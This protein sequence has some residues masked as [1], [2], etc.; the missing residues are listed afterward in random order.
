MTLE[1]KG[2]ALLLRNAL[3]LR[4]ELDTVHKVVTALGVA[5]V[6]DTDANALLDLA[7]ADG[8]VDNDTDSAGV[9]RVHNTSA[10]LV[11]L[12]VHTLL[13]ARVSD[14]V[15]NVACVEATQE[16][17]DLHLSMA[18]E[19]LSEHVTGARPVTETVRHVGEWSVVTKRKPKS[20]VGA[21][22]QNCSSHVKIYWV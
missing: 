20:Q 13:L 14:N 4:V 10:A 3:L 1:V 5:D 2:L 9:H 11:V 6:V 18:L 22:I 15:D 8:L 21:C 7:V 19:L 12:V 17:A 16:A